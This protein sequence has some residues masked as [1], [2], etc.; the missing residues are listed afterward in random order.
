MTVTIESMRAEMQAD[1]EGLVKKLRFQ[2]RQV[3]LRKDDV[4]AA[5]EEVAQAEKQLDEVLDEL[6]QYR[7]SGFEP[8]EAR[9]RAAVSI[10]ED[11]R[12][13]RRECDSQD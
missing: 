2:Q 13:E 7:E 8:K 3:E 11:D 6:E 5:L 12:E 1:V 9:D 10:A 4:Q